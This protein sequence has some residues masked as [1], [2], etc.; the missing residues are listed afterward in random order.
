MTMTYTDDAQ[1]T[2]G[3]IALLST[4]G[5]RLRV[6]L[7]LQSASAKLRQAPPAA[8]LRAPASA[9]T[10]RQ[11]LTLASSQSYT[12]GAWEDALPLVRFVVAFQAPALLEIILD[13]IRVSLVTNFT[14]G[15]FILAAAADSPALAR[16]V[17]KA[18]LDR[19]WGWV[20]GGVPGRAVLDPSGWPAYMHKTCP[21]VWAYALA[22]A[23]KLTRVA[24]GQDEGEL[25]GAAFERV[26]AQARA[27]P[28]AA[29]SSDDETWT[30]GEWTLTSADGVRFHV[31]AYLLL[32]LSPVFRDMASIGSGPPSLEFTDSEIESAPVL[33]LLLH[34]VTTGSLSI[35]AP[36]V[37][38]NLEHVRALVLF[39]RKWQAGPA[40]NH[41][42][43]QV[44]R[45]AERG[46]CCAMRAFMVAAAVEDADLLS[47]LVAKH[48]AFFP[49]SETEG[50][51]GASVWD[52]AAWP[53]SMWTSCPPHYAAAVARAWGETRG[54]SARAREF[55]H[56]FRRGLEVG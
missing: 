17:I 31:P 45:A 34:F 26:L 37:E 43:L 56:A 27:A 19:R 52:P 4:D 16:D 10:L 32:Y 23:W 33:R 47:A 20:G 39:L 14:L 1:W 50:V 49:A 15:A 42:L 9:A 35:S 30:A 5:V 12:L 38:Y 36:A 55:P 40:L 53:L 51:V 48:D 41:A 11:F 21:G 25:L 8:L 7:K 13:A 28:P 18:A 44:E 2:T 54:S 22:R 6:P 46:Q 3:D 29:A 24:E